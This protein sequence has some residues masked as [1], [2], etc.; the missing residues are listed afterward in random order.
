MDTAI[1]S[2]AR[3]HLHCVQFG[4]CQTAMS[5]A[6]QM[7]ALI[8]LTHHAAIATQTY[9]GLSTGTRSITCWRSMQLLTET[10][11]SQMIQIHIRGHVKPISSHNRLRDDSDSEK[12]VE[13]V[14]GGSFFRSICFFLLDERQV[15]SRA[16][17]TAEGAVE[18]NYLTQSEGKQEA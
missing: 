5:H 9:Y 12:Q 13:Q 16:A 10:E 15:V 17:E 6:T 18:V 11:C 4:L 2:A 8:A 1:W 7:Q 14:T 3:S